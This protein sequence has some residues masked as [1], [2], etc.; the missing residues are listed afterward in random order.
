MPI[1][2]FQLAMR[3]KF[4]PCMKLTASDYPAGG[5]SSTAQSASGPN[6]AVR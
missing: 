1:M 3:L 6:R 5:T 2:R 4:P